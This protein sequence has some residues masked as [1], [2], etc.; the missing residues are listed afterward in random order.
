MRVGGGREG[1]G[2]VFCKEQSEGTS[3]AD[4]HYAN[5]TELP[6]FTAVS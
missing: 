2:V 4:A 6:E 3:T 5:N 1:G